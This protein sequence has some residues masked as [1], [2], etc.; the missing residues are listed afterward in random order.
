[1]FPGDEV[2]CYYGNNFFG[3]NNSNCECKA[4]ERY[5]K[6]ELRIYVCMV[7]IYVTTLIYIDV[8]MGPSEKWVWPLVASQTS[9]MAA[10]EETR[11]DTPNGPLKYSLRETEERLK[12]LKSASEGNVCSNNVR[13][14]LLLWEF[15]Y[16]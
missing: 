6:V 10:G 1:M 4:C 13:S 3:D 7:D 12:R 9:T 11:G 16:V 14:Y 15:I 8:G 2:T 5:I